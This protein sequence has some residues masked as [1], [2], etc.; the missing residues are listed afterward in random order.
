TI[1]WESAAK[2]GATRK[3]DVY[4]PA[5]YDASRQ[6]PVAYVH[7]GQQAL[8]DGLMKN[9]L[10]HVAGKSVRSLIAVFIHFDEETPG[11]TRPPAY[12]KMI[13]EELIPLIDEKYSTIAGR[14]S[15]VTIGAGDGANVA[16]TTAFMHSDLFG[17]VG[18]QSA[19]LGFFGPISFAD[20]VKGADEQPMA[21]YL[22]WGTYHLRSPHEA[23]DMSVDSREAFR[24]LREKG[25]RPAGGERPEG[26]GWRCWR[27]NSEELFASLLPLIEP[28]P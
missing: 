24:M 19:N 6:Y 12:Q 23:W 10:D 11:D 26:Y 16:L 2:E 5:G 15:R 20:M 8:E 28:E 14:E 9:T 3:A 13:V 27:A 25:Y 1:E 18:A 22:D 4:L 21:I 7:I 17:G